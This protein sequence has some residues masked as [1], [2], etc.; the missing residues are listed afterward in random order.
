MIERPVQS[1][2]LVGSRFGSIQHA[3]AMPSRLFAASFAPVS[4]DV[5]VHTWYICDLEIGQ[6]PSQAFHLF[7]VSTVSPGDCRLEIQINENQ[8][9]T[10]FES[11]RGI[12]PALDW[13]LRRCRSKELPRLM[14][15]VDGESCDAATL[16]RCATS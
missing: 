14:V 3:A 13:R 5:D 15:T 4:I 2:A 8:T 1:G 7:K 6:V 9:Q 11:L 12:S 10:M 16:L